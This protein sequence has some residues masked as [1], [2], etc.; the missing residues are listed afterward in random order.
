M[1]KVTRD[2]SARSYIATENFAG[3]FFSYS[4]KKVNFN[5]V[6]TLSAVTTTLADC[7]AGRVLRENGRKLAP[8][9]NPSI[10]TYMVGVYDN[11]SGLSGFI[12]PN[13]PVFAVYSNDRPNFLVD[14]VDPSAGG[15]TDKSAPV[16]TNGLV[17]AGIG[18]VAT[19]G[20]IR[21]ANVITMPESISGAAVNI[22]PELG[23]VFK[24]SGNSNFSINA[25]SPNNLAGALL[26]LIV[27]NTQGNSINVSFGAGLREAA[28]LGIGN[29]ETR[30]VTF[31][32]DGTSF[33]EISRSN[34]QSVGVSSN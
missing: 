25:P 18:L 29:V 11:Q 33:F 3:D 2:L 8:G 28:V 26:Y 12:D 27:T 21:A 10:T 32:S 9:M 22:N 15:L 5:T 34:N 31:V 14:S 6:G 23:Q 16:L 24:I 1:A 17:T 30:T 19:T 20:Q 7:P 4:V 13:A